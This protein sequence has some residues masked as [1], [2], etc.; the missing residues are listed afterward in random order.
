[1]T[2]SSSSTNN[3]MGPVTYWNFPENAYEKYAQDAR[4]IEA[5]NKDQINAPNIAKSTQ[6]VDETKKPSEFDQ[7]F[8]TSTK[9]IIKYESIFEGL[10]AY[11][12]F[13]QTNL[14]LFGSLDN[15]KSK[16]EEVINFS[17]STPDLSGSISLESEKIINLQKCLVGLCKDRE[18]ISANMG[19]LLK[20]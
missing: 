14:N 13:K 3:K 12:G 5:W 8:G 4:T 1:M 7:L 15:L 6:V 9:G 16:M 2:D 18:S 17:T 20:G 11:S 10:T 19:K